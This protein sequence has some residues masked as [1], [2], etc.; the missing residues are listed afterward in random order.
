[1]TASAAI[2][3]ASVKLQLGDVDPTRDWLSMPERTRLASMIS[4]R[5]RDQFIA[6]RWLAR[7]ALAAL[8]GGQPQEWQLSAAV[9]A[10]PQV[11]SGPRVSG[12]AIG[13][14]HSG[15][16]V[17][18]VLA[19]CAVGIDVER[20]ARRALDVAGLVAVVLSDAE[21]ACWS[22]RPAAA[23]EVEFLGWWTLKEAWLKAHGRTLNPATLR[24]IEA[25]PS[26][27]MEANARLWR[28]DDFTLA[29]VGLDA[30]APLDVAR[31]MPRCQTQWWTVRERRSSSPGS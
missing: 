3:C 29:L 10:P 25:L 19:D 6:G 2:W 24:D 28:E 8:H 14:S 13:L 16:T 4:P 20:H 26:D 7:Q 17:A 30:A 22:A 27:K 31:P 18:C 11:T 5:R 15:D 23:R 1:M 9:D 12:I 21:R